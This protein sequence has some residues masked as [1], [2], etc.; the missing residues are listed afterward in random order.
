ME[1]FQKLIDF[2]NLYN[3]CQVS[4]KGKGKKVSAAKFN[5][6]ALEHIY[7]MKKQLKSHTYRVS[8]YS[9]FIVSEPKKRVIKA[10]SFRDKVLQHCLC[11]YVLLPKMKDIF[12]RDNYAGQKGKGTLFGLNRLSENLTD[13]YAEHKTN[14]YILKCDITKFF[15]SINHDIMKECVDLYFA[16]EDIRW[17]CDLFIDSVDGDGLPLGNQCS[18]V[19]ALMYLSGLDYFI[20]QELGCKYYGRYMDDFYLLSDDKEYLKHCLQ[21]IEKYLAGLKLTLNGKTEIVPMSKGIRFLGFH[22]YLTDDGKVIRKLTGEN[23]RKIKKRLR[24]YAKLVQ[25]GKMTREKFNERYNSWKNHASHGNCY[26]L[27]CEMDD[28]VKTLFG[29]KQMELR[30][31]I[32]GS[33]DFDDYKYLSDTLDAF[34]KEHPDRD[35][36]VVSGM[37]RGADKLGEKYAL[38]RK[39]LVRR[40]PAKWDK[41]GKAAGYI[42]NNEMLD[43]IQQSNCENAVIAFWDGKSKGTKHTIDNAKKRDIPTYVYIKEGT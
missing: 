34:I 1:D 32:A 13:F 23:K 37:A 41:L 10:G 22:T 12:I 4:L 3:S 25:E 36:V 30:I 31:I 42:R 39:Y 35:I 11:D 5:V 15:Y 18:Q 20:T 43:F 29:E 26:K 24:I 6:M 19:F 7:M 17:V 33:R 8:P 40:F 16:D 28:F 9:E 14:G 38:E 27:L 2:G 21:E